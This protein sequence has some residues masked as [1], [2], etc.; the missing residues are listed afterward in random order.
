MKILPR[1]RLRRCAGHRAIWA[2]AADVYQHHLRLQASR[3]SHIQ[4]FSLGS[5]RPRARIRNFRSFRS[6]WL[7]KAHKSAKR[8]KRAQ[9]GAR[10]GCLSLPG[11]ASAPEEAVRAC[12]GA[13]SAV[14]KAVRACPVPPGRSK[15]LPNCAPLETC[16]SHWP[17]WCSI[18]YQARLEGPREL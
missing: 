9:K 6:R 14:E 2:G 12:F 18:G 5:G 7:K 17:L 13:D 10:K 4:M 16:G 3:H 1:G 8:R 15:K 11:A